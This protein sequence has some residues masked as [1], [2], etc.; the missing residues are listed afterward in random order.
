MAQSR[1]LTTVQAALRVLAYLLAHPEGLEAAQVARL[2]GKS[3]STAYALLASLVAEGFAERVGTTYRVSQNALSPVSGPGHGDTNAL[4]R[5]HDALEELYL[6]TRER[7]YLALLTREGKL[8]L[9]SRG[10]QGQPKPPGLEGDST[11]ALHALALG[12]AVLAYLDAAPPGQLRAYTPN[13]LTEPVAL[14]DELDRVRQMGFAVELEEFAEGISA[15]AAPVFGPEGRVIGAFG[16]VVP[17]RRFPYAFTRLAH[18]VRE[19]ARA[20]SGHLPGESHPAP[21]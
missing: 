12:K 21:P 15:V 18:A 2:L 6:R 1:K 17:S 7:T 11:E 20:A 4:E 5:L 14:Q 8:R 10:R 13:T 3:L 19:V 16:V 9:Q